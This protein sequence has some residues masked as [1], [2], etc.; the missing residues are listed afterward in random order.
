MNAYPVYLVD[1]IPGAEGRT[2]EWLSVCREDRKVF[3]THETTRWT[4]RWSCEDRKRPFMVYVGSHASHISSHYT[5][6]AAE[7]AAADYAKSYARYDAERK[8]KKA[9]AA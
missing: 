8:A 3:I 2:V 5:L 9:I 1:R 4:G 6:A 7:K